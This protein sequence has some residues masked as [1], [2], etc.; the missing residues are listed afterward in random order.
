[1][2]SPLT[3]IP[4]LAPAP[5]PPKPKPA[6]APGGDLASLKALLAQAEAAKSADADPEPTAA[7]SSVG[8]LAGL[9]KGLGG[10]PEEEAAPEADSSAFATPAFL[11]AAAAP[12]PEP[13]QISDESTSLNDSLIA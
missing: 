8:G 6:A 13:T 12:A 10:E 2:R 11:S 4:A 5:P 1:M 9:L 7:A 3:G